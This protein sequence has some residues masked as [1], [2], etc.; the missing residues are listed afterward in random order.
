[1]K[2]L[3]LTDRLER[4]SDIK[5]LLKIILS[6][7]SGM[8][9]RVDRLFSAH[10]HV[11]LQLRNSR[12]LSALELHTTIAEH[13]GINSSRIVY[14]LKNRNRAQALLASSVYLRVLHSKHILR[15][16][17]R[18]TSKKEGKPHILTSSRRQLRGRVTSA[19]Y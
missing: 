4:I 14:T 6:Q 9:V 7:D 18:T 5:N 17:L 1:V 13:N 19:Q 12:E 8:L 11:P 3:L 10:L 2:K 15:L 16:L